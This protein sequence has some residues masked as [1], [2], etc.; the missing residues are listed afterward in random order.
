MIKYNINDLSNTLK[1]SNEKIVL[2]GAGVIGEISLYAMK[3]ISINVD[4][5]CDSS[6]TKQGKSYFGIKTISPEEL[7]KF[8]TKTNIF[9]GNNYVSTIF[10]Q[11]KK[12]NFSNIY[13]CVELLEKTN[14]YSN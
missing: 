11:L 13:D 12:K 14:F 3:Q 5:F 2:F 10:S 6:T 9:I 4:F 8:N 1:K 7:A